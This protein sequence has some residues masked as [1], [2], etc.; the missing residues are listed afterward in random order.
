MTLPVL[1]DEHMVWG[2][3]PKAKQGQAHVTQFPQTG[4]WGGGTISKSGK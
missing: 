3:E 4:G 1:S 2:G